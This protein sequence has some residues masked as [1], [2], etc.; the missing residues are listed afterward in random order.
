MEDIS[1]GILSVDAWTQ[2]LEKLSDRCAHE[3]SKFEERA[4]RIGFYLAVLS[5]PPVRRFLNVRMTEP[6]LEMSLD[7]GDVEY[8]ARLIAGFDIEVNSVGALGNHRYRAVLRTSE[9]SIV[10]GEGDT[11]VLAILG[12]W[13]NSLTLS[14]IREPSVFRKAAI[15]M[16]SIFKMGSRQVD[17]V[18]MP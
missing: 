4:V 15:S 11:P 13:A 17:C 8:A 5:P 2:E 9:S 12:A 6:E 10:E 14:Q 7:L 1:A 16:R 18:R 3:T